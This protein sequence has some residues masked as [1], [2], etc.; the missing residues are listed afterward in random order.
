[1]LRYKQ[2]GGEDSDAIE[3]FEIDHIAPRPYGNDA[4]TDT[5]G[6]VYFKEDIE[7]VRCAEINTTCSLIIE[8][9]TVYAVNTEKFQKALQ[10]SIQEGVVQEVKDDSE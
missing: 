7:K 6:N 8:Q 2:V 9:G 4:V 5:E 1:M 3:L 10:E